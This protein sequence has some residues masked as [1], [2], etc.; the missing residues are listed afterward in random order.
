VR[1]V[2]LSGDSDAAATN[3]INVAGS[4]TQ[5]LTLTGSGGVDQITGGAG[6]DVITGGAGS[7][8][9]TLG[10][11]LDT[12]AFNS[13]TGTDTVADY[14]VAD[15]SITL[16]KAIFTALGAVGALSAA[17]FESGA[18]TAAATAAGR[19]VYNTGTGALYYDVDGL[20]GTAAVQ[21]ATLIG[22]PTLVVGEFSI[23]A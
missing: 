21:I 16:S 10:T 14:S 5:S 18:L 7:D 6:N 20:G 2:D 9:I 13:L 4:A 11:G 3:V 19:I 12:L 17:E 1:N 23:V 15:D 22:N 8:T